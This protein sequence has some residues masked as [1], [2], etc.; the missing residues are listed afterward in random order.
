MEKQATGTEKTFEERLM[1]LE[2]I[3]K[4]A[5]SCLKQRIERLEENYYVSKEMLPTDEAARYMGMSKG[6]FQKLVSAGAIPRH[7]PGGKLTY[8]D[9]EDLNKYM[10]RNY[11][12]AIDIVLLGDETEIH[13][14]KE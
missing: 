13:E 11:L 4:E 12:P 3:G 1:A 7:A 6:W 9:R 14:H 8:F 10:R 2:N 5:I